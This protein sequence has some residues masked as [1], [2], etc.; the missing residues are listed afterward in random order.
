MAT[1][2]FEKCTCLHG[3]RKPN[4]PADWS[5]RAVSESAQRLHSLLN[6]ADMLTEKPELTET[7]I[8]ALDV[9][10]HAGREHASDIINQIAQLSGAARDTEAL[11]LQ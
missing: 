3:D 11:E 2:V 4:F 1:D 10:L 5:L 6:V 7:D 8:I 9:L